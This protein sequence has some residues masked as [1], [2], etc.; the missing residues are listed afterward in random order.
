MRWLKT[1]TEMLTQYASWVG[2]DPKPLIALLDYPLSIVLP[3]FKKIKIFC[4][5]H[6]DLYG[7]VVRY[8]V[9]LDS[10]SGIPPMSLRTLGDDPHRWLTQLVPSE[11]DRFF[12]K[13]QFVQ[14]FCQLTI[15]SPPALLTLD[16][17]TL[18]RW[19]WVTNG[20]TKY[21]KLELNGQQI[22]TKFGAAVSLTDSELL[23]IVHSASDGKQPIGVFVK[24]DEASFKRRLIANVPLGGYI[25]ASYVR[26]LIESFL[27]KM[28][29]FEKLS[30]SFRDRLDVISLL[31]KGRLC[32]PLDESAYDYHVTRD[33]W[34]GFFDFLDY[35]FPENEGCQALK[36][37]FN[38]AIWQF[39]GK[40]GRWLK[41]MPSGLAL[42]TMVNSWMNYIKQ[43]TIVT[44]DVHWAC[45][46][47]V[48]TF[49]YNQDVTLE[50]IEEA[51]SRF[52]SSA[53]A[54]KNW[55][56]YKFGEYLKTIYGREGTSGYP[57]RIFGSLLY[58]Q[59]LSF[60]RP[61][62][63]LY[64]LVDLWKQLFDRL[65]LP[66]DEKVVCRDL[67]SAVSH[68]VQGFNSKTAS[69]WLHSPKIHGGFGKLPY[70]NKTFT[71]QIEEQ[72]I[73]FYHLSRYRLPRVVD[74]YG[75]VE[76][77]VGTYHNTTNSY[78]T[79]PPY[80]LP[81]IANEEEWVKRLNLEDL[82]RRGPFTSMVLDQIPLPVIDFV[83]VANMSMF[84]SEFQFNVY[85][86]LSGSWNAI[87]SKLINASLA[88]VRLVTT[89]MSQNNISV[90][91]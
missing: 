68:K 56:S 73:S 21:S 29:G 40:S 59:D 2:F 4:H 51:Y 78:K 33:S 87:A 48:L 1:P 37:Y 90:F 22:K 38:H 62:E 16:E 88:L 52:G 71:W 61:D 25:I 55:K 8:F 85:P 91:V 50:E 30:P 35:A 72:R 76:L 82:P 60:R 23:D 49:P 28:P 89:T 58:T 63:K 80:V 43:K 10:I 31:R 66:M 41:G 57:A 12:W 83:S 20:A 77:V 67:A 36:D 42:T 26:Y 74:Y 54:A 53:N 32:L 34:L 13:D 17:F 3:L 18:N 64:E 19:L 65:G 70:N 7:A 81:P 5:T 75:K 14:T 9:D 84:A 79:G 44:A 24:G 15:K 6:Y 11:Y 45:G 69:E 86:N 27:G 47:D 39:D 46:D